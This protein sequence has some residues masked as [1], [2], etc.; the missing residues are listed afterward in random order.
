MS[1]S[2]EESVPP[3][4]W[5]D[6][7][8]EVIQP[9]RPSAES[10]AKDEEVS[11]EAMRVAIA[12]A[13]HS[14]RALPLLTELCSEL[15]RE[16]ERPTSGHLMISYDELLSAA[17]R[18]DFHLMWLP[19]LVAR[20]AISSGSATAL[21]VPVRAGST[22]YA[23]ALFTRDD[24]D[25]RRVDELEGKRVAWV[26]ENSLAG[27]VLPRALLRGRGLQVDSLFAEEKLLGSHEAVVAAVCK[28]EVDVGAT[29]ARIERDDGGTEMVTSKA[30]ASK[31][32]R[33]LA[34]HGPVPADLL[35]VGREVDAKTRDRLRRVL[36][37][38]PDAELTQ[39]SCR[40]LECDGFELLDPLH[41]RVL[42]ELS[43][44]PDPPA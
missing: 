37:T 5:E 13:V 3:P 26:D 34:H 16:M 17:E 23:T 43:V 14:R 15:R 19:P 8:S 32:T 21:A 41:L 30:L 40:L 29:F 18:D 27:Y 1:D 36:V 39:V 2:S 6:D 4:T 10:A 42:D 33:I 9:S 20:K 28:G 25:I 24:S 22:G 11:G 44:H 12:G 7:V 38:Q 31:P 35:A